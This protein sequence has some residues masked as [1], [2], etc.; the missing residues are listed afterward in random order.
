MGPAEARKTASALV[1]RAVLVGTTTDAAGTQPRAGW[2]RRGLWLACLLWLLAHAAALLAVPAH[3]GLPEWSSLQALVG[4]RLAVVMRLG[5]VTC[6][7]SLAWDWGRRR[8]RLEGDVGRLWRVGA[9]LTLAFSIL[10]L[11]HIG[12][13]FHVADP[14][15]TQELPQLND[16]LAGT[17]SSTQWGVPWFAFAYLVGSI[18]AGILSAV[19]AWVVLQNRAGSR[20]TWRAQ[21]TRRFI[22]ICIGILVTGASLRALLFFATGARFWH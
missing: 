7:A 10:H 1:C 17:L 15:P 9:S 4:P 20:D 16:R 21:R 11:A 12:S 19:E 6:L 2:F 3:A 18:A 8:L 13:V 5:F 22:S 14:I